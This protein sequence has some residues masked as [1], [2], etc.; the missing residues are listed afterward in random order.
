MDKAKLKKLYWKILRLFLPGKLALK[1][2]LALRCIFE[3]WEF[4]AN[5][6]IFSS[7]FASLEQ[8]GIRRQLCGL[9]ERSISVAEEY[10]RRCR[11]LEHMKGFPFSDGSCVL[12]L[13]APLKNDIICVPE[14]SADLKKYQK[15]YGFK[16]GAEILIYQHGL[17]FWQDEIRPFLK[18]KVFVDAGAC[19]GELVPALLEYSPSK[20][21]AFE[22]SSKNVRRFHKEMRK[23]R[24]P[25]EKVEIIS[26]DLGDRKCSMCLDDQGGCGQTLSENSDDAQCEVTTLDEF[27]ADREVSGIGLIKSDVEGMGLLLLHGAI[28][29]IKRD[30]PVL[31]LAAYHNQDELLGQYAFLKREL[32][33]YHFE[34]RDL[35]PGSC[36]EVTLLGI[37]VE[38]LRKE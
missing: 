6:Y 33:D 23:R 18:G 11:N 22:P 36:F 20:I 9:D 13:A 10:V 14:Q 26:A 12:I 25:L 35:P 16:T 21:Y 15:K 29:T 30:R 24:I 7:N 27:A 32:N 31:S 2:N 28:R 19:I 37:P 1:L 3:N 8:E 4:A 17:A 5:I 34:L 38:I